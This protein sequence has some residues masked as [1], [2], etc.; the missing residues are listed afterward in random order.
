MTFMRLTVRDLCYRHRETY[1]YVGSKS[2]S[3]RDGI[4]PWFQRIGVLDHDQVYHSKSYITS[5]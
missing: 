5:S 3:F 2:I 4:G 1:Y